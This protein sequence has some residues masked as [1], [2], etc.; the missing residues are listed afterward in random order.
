MDNDDISKRDNNNNDAG[1]ITKVLQTR[2]CKL[3]MPIFTT[4][5]LSII[6]I[7]FIS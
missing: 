1:I 4:K 5:V 6:Y 3:N 2:F 7:E